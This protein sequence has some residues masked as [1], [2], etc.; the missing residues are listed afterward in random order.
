M[1]THFN[2]KDK[3][4]QISIIPEEDVIKRITS[5]KGLQQDCSM[6]RALTNNYRKYNQ[7][8]FREEKERVKTK[9]PGFIPAG[10]FSSRS[11]SS[12]TKYWG[13]IVL[14]FANV[15]NPEL[16]RSKIKNKNDESVIMAFLSPSG[17]GLKVI[18]KLELP[19]LG[20]IEEII[21]YHKQAH[22]ALTDHHIKNYGITSLDESG[23][24]LA[25]LCYYSH[26][27]KAY[28]NP[29]AK[30]WKFNYNLR[31]TP[32]NP[33]LNS[34]IK[35]YYTMFSEGDERTSRDLVEELIHWSQR[36]NIAFLDHLNDWIMALIAIKNSV[37]ESRSGWEL[38]LRLGATIRSFNT[39]Q[40][41][42]MWNNADLE[43][44]G[45]KVTMGT[46]A[47][48]ARRMGWRKPKNLFLDSGVR[49]NAFV[50]AME[51]SNI[52]LKYNEL[53]HQIHYAISPDE[54][55]WMLW[56]DLI[57][58]KI[59]LDIL[60]SALKREEYDSFIKY[61][62]P[63]YNPI[64]DF[65]NSL[66]EWDRKDRFTELTNTLV[67]KE[68][69]DNTISEML[70]KRWMIGVINGLHNKPEYEN[71]PS[72][73]PNENLLIL[74]GPQGIG[75]TRWMR[76][77]MPAGWHNLLAEKLSFNF[78]D[79]DDKL[80]S[81]EKA[82]ICMDELSPVLNN[83]ATNE[84]LKGFLSQKTFNVRVA[85]GKTNSIF[86]KTASFI[87]TSN[88]SEII[89]DP[90]G[91]RRFWPIEIDSADYVHEVDMLQLWSQAFYLWKEG[92][93][94]WLTTSEQKELAKYNEP[95]RKVHPYEEYINRFVQTGDGRYTA[96]QIAEHINNQ[97]GNKNA[98][99]PNI[100]GIYMKK[101]GYNNVPKFH[102]GKTHRIYQVILLQE[103]FPDITS[104]LLGEV[105]DN[106]Q[107]NL[108]DNVNQDLFGEEPDNE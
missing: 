71:N 89:T 79:K 32:H 77:L 68:E 29:N 30:G 58:G 12:I 23:S 28:Y 82:I 24:D 34:R 104:H 7:E 11:S 3:I 41:E 93:Q 80:L 13:R 74:I 85:Y 81:C 83:R 107:E 78:D 16:L 51:E 53:T 94:H 46:L 50:T 27:N 48:A 19:Q 55:N 15:Q 105:A 69:T 95:Y 102:N 108:P 10:E 88:H 1:Y 73:S 103:N 39:E 70:L 76:K 101:A 20:S 2:E 86:Y 57:D 66:P 99:N 37:S 67:L 36:E 56:D 61:I 25:R 44:L 49:F 31:L 43:D 90:T 97:I 72:I 35:G 21:D 26:D 87:G 59:R 5:D 98:A 4:D 106:D 100:L 91:S 22:K 62:P 40:A 33:I 42:E 18:H 60:Q 9:L 8:K 17:T 75:K 96:T 54:E 6:I 47:Y 38:F 92:E 52:R 65:L 63:R 45:S 84:Q 64:I 14:D